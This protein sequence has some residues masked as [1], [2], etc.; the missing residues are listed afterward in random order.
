MTAVLVKVILDRYDGGQNP[1][2]RGGG[3]AM[4]STEFPD[5]GDQMLI[6]RAPVP[7]TFRPGSA[8]PFIEVIA[9]DSAGPQQ[10]DGTPGWSW[11]ISYDRE[12][13]GSPQPASYYVLSANGT[14]QRL[15]Q[16]ATAPVAQPGQQYVPA[17]NVPPG[18]GQVLGWDGSETEWVDQSGGGGSGTV[19]SVNDVDPDGAGNVELTPASVGAAP[20]GAATWYLDDYTGTDDEKMTSALAAW[21][22]SAAGGTVEL[23]AR[24]HTFADPWVTEYQ[25]SAVTPRYL[26]VTGAGAGFNGMWASTASAAVTPVT[27][28]CTGVPACMQFMHLG[29][30]QVDGLWIGNASTGVPLVLVTNATPDI[31]GC[32]FAGG[33]FGPACTTDAI[34]LGG[35]GVTTGPGADAQYQGYQGNVAR[36]FFDGI[37]RAVTWRNAANAVACTY[38]TISANCGSSEPEG[39]PFV[40]VGS[41][42]APFGNFVKF[43]C[44]ETTNYAYGAACSGGASQNMLGP[45]G[46]YDQGAGYVAGYYLEYG[47]GGNVIED[48]GTTTA[49]YPIVDDRNPLG[50]NQVG[51]IASPAPGK[52]MVIGSAVQ[53]A[54]AAQP[55][56]ILSGGQHAMGTAPNGNMGLWV[57]TE[58]A[59]PGLQA[60]YRLPAAFTDGQVTEG[61]Q[62]LYSATGAFTSADVGQAI[63]A[64]T[65]IPV[66]SQIASAWTASTLPAWQPATAYAAGTMAR[67]AT[68]NGYVYACSTAGTTA[69]A[70]PAWPVTVGGTVADGTAAWTCLGTGT[71]CVITQAASAAAT[72]LAFQLSRLSAAQQAGIILEGPHLR[73]GNF[74]SA[75]AGPGAGT[76]GTA[77]PAGSDLAGAVYIAAGTGTSAG[78]LFTVTF[79]TPY[80][81]TP[82]VTLA[83]MDAVAATLLAG[84]YYVTATETGFTVYTVSAPAAGA[85]YEISYTA[86]QPY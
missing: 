25:G 81:V 48:G 21:A 29:S 42:D 26:R 49:A 74:A 85:F 14:T 27:F 78:V 55:P 34:V 45:N 72:G 70:A 15:S 86:I 11:V 22:A 41:G 63:Y 79:G 19:T 13:P 9:N 24:A 73:G 75:A 31:H 4:P 83:A 16:L 37:R 32:V 56:Q 82:V 43:N 20:A 36:N 40:L 54:Y 77:T 12:T 80:T 46:L 52:N 64:A 58:S 18:S 38:N 67:P 47:S 10:E 17:P 65:C 8:P 3:W 62:W 6:G 5:P 71:A 60:A 59:I 66:G 53:F 57:T 68:A 84:G 44:V 51:V 50:L 33:G 39:A 1:Y 28:T 69:S 35:T 76:G 30:V 61:S 23:A 2:A 7:F